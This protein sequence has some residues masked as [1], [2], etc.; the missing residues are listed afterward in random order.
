MNPI[1]FHNG[2][3]IN[4]GRNKEFAES[5]INNG[6]IQA[7]WQ[8]IPE[9]IIRKGNWDLIAKCHAKY[10]PCYQNGARTRDINALKIF[11]KSSENDLWITRYSD[12][13]SPSIQYL[14]WCIIK[15]GDIQ[16]ENQ[17]EKNGFVYR[18]TKSDWSNEDLNGKILKVSGSHLDKTLGINGQFHDVAKTLAFKGTLCRVNAIDQLMDLIN[19]EI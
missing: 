14:Y 17:S 7:G 4:L 5:S 2:Y 1:K 3:F 9:K 8:K 15:D 6:I 18:E 19:G 16:Y 10:Y 13:S 11:K 12:K